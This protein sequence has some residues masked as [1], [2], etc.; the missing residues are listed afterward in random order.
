MCG[1]CVA[2]NRLLE[3][4]MALGTLSI[5]SGMQ[6]ECR[7]LSAAGGLKEMRHS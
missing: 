7:S 6:E 1:G 2:D 4:G 5:E 3:E